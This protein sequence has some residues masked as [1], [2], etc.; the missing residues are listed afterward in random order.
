MF[1]SLFAFG[2]QT[3]VA[4]F[5]LFALIVQRQKLFDIQIE[6]LFLQLVSDL[7]RILSNHF[8]I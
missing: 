5:R 3:L 2:Q 4:G 6:T 7:G 8:Y 1:R